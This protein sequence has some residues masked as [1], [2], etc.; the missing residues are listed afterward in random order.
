MCQQIGKYARVT[1]ISSIK[2]V[3]TRKD[4]DLVCGVVS[5]RC[6]AGPWAVDGQIIR[7]AGK[8]LHIAFQAPNRIISRGCGDCSCAWARCQCAA[9]EI[10]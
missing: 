10:I 7:R 2:I 4:A 3:R 5:D 6:V 9:T 1:V 8:V